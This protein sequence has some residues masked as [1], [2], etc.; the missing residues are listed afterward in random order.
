MLVCVCVGVRVCVRACLR[1]C[2][3]AYVAC[4]VNI[5]PYSVFMTI[6]VMN[7]DLMSYGCY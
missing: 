5:N 3:R 1:A 6:D 7:K 4:I 2:V